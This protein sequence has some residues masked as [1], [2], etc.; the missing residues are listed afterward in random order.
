MK[1]FVEFTFIALS[2]ILLSACSNKSPQKSNIIKDPSLLKPVP[3]KE[4]VFYY[5]N[6][7]FDANDYNQVI[8]P[9]ITIIV[10]EDDKNDIDKK[11]LNKITSYLQENLQKELNK[12]LEVNTSKKALIMQISIASFDVSYDA[13]KPWQ[14]MP[15][16]LAIKTIMRGTGLEKR[17][18]N[19]SLVFKISDKNTSQTQVLIVDYKTKED[20]PSYDE[21]SFENVKPLLDYWINNSKTK[22]KELNDHK[23]EY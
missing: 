5:L 18:L 11:L 1:R 8:V 17:K 10:E 9:E 4:D 6:K 15:Y 3:N 2:I 21:L 23:Y 20:M 14:Y 16:G 7:S 19:T 22:L 12:V 13:L